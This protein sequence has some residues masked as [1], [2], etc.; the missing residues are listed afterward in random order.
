MQRL[1]IK[2]SFAAIDDTGAISGIAWPYNSG[3]DRMGD[4][5]EKNA[6]TFPSKLP[7]LFSHDPEMPVGVWDEIVETPAGLQVKGRLLVNDVARAREV[8]ALVQ[9]G[10]VTGLSIGYSVKRALGRKGGGRTIQS[11]ELVEVSLVAIP[12]HPGARVTS[13]K[14]ATELLAIAEAINRAASAY[15]QQGS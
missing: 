13:A 9:A 14:S 2:A 4:I 6:F 7:M 8:R 12:M 10:A 15:S 3:P 5:I 1:E 11:L